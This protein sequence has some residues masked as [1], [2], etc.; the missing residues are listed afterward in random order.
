MI[1]KSNPLE[2][3]MFSVII[4]LFNKENS[5]YS[6]IQSVINQNYTNFELIV[7]NDGSTDNSLTK[8]QSIY[9]PRIKIFNK[10]NGGVSS[11]R[12]MG[13]EL[14]N[15]EFVVFLDADDLW[16]PFCLDEFAKLIA[17]FP[18]A[19]VFCTNYNMTGKSLIGSD[20]MYYVKDYYLTSAYFMAKWSIPLLITGCVSVR[21]NLFNQVGYF[22]QSLSHG[23]DVDMWER[24]AKYGNFA[25]SEKVTTIY[26]TEAENRA[27]HLDDRSGFQ[28]E[29]GKDKRKKPMNK[30]QRIYYG[31]QSI[32]ELRSFLL[33]GKFLNIL[34]N[35]RIYLNLIIKGLL[36]IIKVRILK[37]PVNYRY[38]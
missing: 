13:I 1:S 23:E 27:S 10:H 31:V 35:E 25:K 2:S 28:L 34:S 37:C 26:R 16:L 14:S 18:L 38:S 11:A 24:L 32:F 19:D 5:I 12:N 20:L 30:S 9:D 7:V 8:A 15:G 17:K 36:Y 3:I 4:P 33:S 6:T 21:K 22:D 29:W